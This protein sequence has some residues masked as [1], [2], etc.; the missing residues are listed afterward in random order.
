MHRI[1]ALLAVVVSVVGITPPARADES[2]DSLYWAGYM[3]QRT[4]GFRSVSARWTVPDITCDDG[5]DSAVGI[6]VGMGSQTSGEN[7]V[8]QTG[9]VTECDD[10]VALHRTFV[11]AYPAKPVY[12]FAVNPGDTI[13]ARITMGT[14]KFGYF[15]MDYNTAESAFGEL[16][17]TARGRSAE[18]I[19]E[20]PMNDVMPDFG[21]I[22]VQN[23]KINDLPIGLRS[24]VHW[25][26]IYTKPRD[27]RAYA[28]R[29]TDG[30][31]DFNVYFQKP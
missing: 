1:A 14:E 4:G 25:T 21:R 29:L 19:V 11:E 24:L 15:I 7:T 3:A 5:E 10:G 22:E 27:V 30:G 6:W 26:M 13:H 23:A 12:L 8:D 28:S 16:P 2:R 17:T 9:T 18:V 31:R 20:G